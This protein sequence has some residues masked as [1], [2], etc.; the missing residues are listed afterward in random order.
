MNI[1]KV[2]AR[3]SLVVGE[4]VCHSIQLSLELASETINC[5]LGGDSLWQPVPFNWCCNCKA[6]PAYVLLGAT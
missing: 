4:G 2:P 5:L 6:T 1:Q 3:V